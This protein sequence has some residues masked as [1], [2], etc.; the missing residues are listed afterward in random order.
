[1]AV[2]PRSDAST[3]EPPRLKRIPLTDAADALAYPSTMLRHPTAAMVVLMREVARIA[4][5]RVDDAT[6]DTERM[7]F[8]HW[9]VL[10]CLD[11][12]GA[13]SQRDISRR[14]GF[15]PSDLVA[16]VD[17]LEEAGFVERRRDERDRRRY[18]VDVTTAGRRALRARARMSERLNEEVLRG[19][20][21][22]ERE[23]LLELLR[24]AVSAIR[25]TA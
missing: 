24:R 23:T 2:N 19:L 16:L 5:R 1:M 8:P 21:E 14:L 15:D 12:F 13:A 10:A 25:P 7:R 11:E 3:S 22:R 18:A 20:T 9:A 4:Q 17:W 6:T